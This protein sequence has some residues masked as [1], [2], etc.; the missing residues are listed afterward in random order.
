[1]ISLTSNKWKVMGM[2]PF[3]PFLNKS[4]ETGTNLKGVTDWIDA[5]VPGSIHNDLLK[6]G[7]IE[8]PHFEK[9][10]IKCE[11]V[12][13]R[14]WI[15]KT[16]IYISSEKKAK[17]YEIIFKGVDYKAH[18]Y[19]NGISLGQHTG[20]YRS[21]IFNINDILKFDANNKLEVIFEHAPGEMGQIG[22]TKN[23]KAQKSRFNYKWDFSTRLVDAGLYDEVFINALG[24]NKLEDIY[25]KTS[26]IDNNT[27]LLKLDCKIKS[28]KNNNAV[29]NMNIYL[30]G[31]LLSTLKDNI[32]LSKGET[33]YQN[34]IK[35]EN[36]E[37]WYP[38]GHGKQPLYEM[39]IEVSDDDGIS[40]TDISY[41][42]FRE[43]KYV[44]N[45]GAASDSLPYG[46]VINNKRIYMKG[47]NITPLDHMYGRLTLKRYEDLIRLIKEANINLI[48]VWGGGL[49]EKKDFY[50]LCD[51]YGIMIWQ[52]FIQ[53]SSGINNEPC[54]D[55][56]YLEFL[57]TTCTHV[58]KE[59][60]NH[61]ALVYWSGG[62]EL[63][64]VNTVPVSY[65]NINIKMLKEI[66]DEYD[67]DRFMLPTSGSGPRLFMETKENV[68]NHDVHGPWKYGGIFEHYEMFNKSNSQLHSE[69]GVD[70]MGN[71]E[72]LK[73][74]LTKENLKVD[75]MDDSLIWRHH[76]E[77]WDTYSRDVEIFGEFENLES[78]IMCSQFIQAEGIRYGLEANRRRMHYNSGSIIW[79]FNEPWPNVSCTCIADYYN[80][81]KLAYHFLKKAY[82][83]IN[84]SLRYEKLIYNSE[85]K[86]EGEI[87]ISNDNDAFECE[88]LYESNDIN[89][90]C[91]ISDEISV[92]AEGNASIKVKN[93]SFDIPKDIEAFSIKL[94]LLIKDEIIN[95]EYIFFTKSQQK[96]KRQEYISQYLERYLS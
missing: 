28:F 45:K 27:G 93:I 13:N 83:S 71:L 41:I 56:D 4:M 3:T 82:R 84:V 14:W 18:F 7:L 53:S 49:I 17:N 85:E 96:S 61:A 76:G 89:G 67:F 52:E 46:L 75:N 88:L 24:N 39:K 11:W 22:Y 81:P 87:Y 34:E 65:E 73:K 66:V 32:I 59:K 91:I 95:N 10:S 92:N 30:K 2:W 57:K 9:N 25:Y 86:F 35:V 5:T 26:F 33:S 19:L 38:S 58:V 68:F 94:S 21:A 1:M 8:D 60:R 69:F 43:I 80:T 55:M 48:R 23:I 37:L 72:T 16:N 15:Y 20:M 78:F 74:I 47:V 31:K 77:W 54:T 90:N 51:K 29:I 36:V 42:G 79:Q 6:A 44:L 40:D 62:N 64:D 50:D 63:T 12:S 70:G